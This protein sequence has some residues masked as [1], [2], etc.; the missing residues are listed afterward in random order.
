MCNTND[1]GGEKDDGDIH[2]S[3]TGY[4]ELAKLVNLAYEANPA[5]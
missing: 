3:P 4:K 5:K 1:S 2:P